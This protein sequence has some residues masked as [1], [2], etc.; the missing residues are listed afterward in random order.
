[1]NS[2]SIGNNIKRGFRVGCIIATILLSI[3]WGFRYNQ[4]EDLTL[5]DY[6]DSNAKV[7]PILSLCL[8]NPFLEEQLKIMLADYQKVRP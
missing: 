1:M 6:K 5:V 8:S 2:R 3:R 7:L 4:D